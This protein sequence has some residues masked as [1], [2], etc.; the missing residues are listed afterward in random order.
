MKP[1]D[2]ANNLPRVFRGDCEAA[3]GIKILVTFNLSQIRRK[4]LA[5]GLVT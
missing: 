2:V 1:D 5:F 3:P 4:W